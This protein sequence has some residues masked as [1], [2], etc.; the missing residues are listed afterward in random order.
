[1]P[2][3]ETYLFRRS[4]LPEE[5]LLELPLLLEREE[6]PDELAAGALPELRDL[7]GALLA[8]GAGADRLR[9][10]ALPERL[11][12]AAGWLE[13]LSRLGATR[14][15]SAGAAELERLRFALP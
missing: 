12:L 13:L 11:P 15:R 10:V 4:P 3:L 6:P 9:L 5:E 1:M 8:A 14:L 7:E 2:R